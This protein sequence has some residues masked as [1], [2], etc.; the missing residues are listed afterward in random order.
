MKQ[1]TADHYNRLARMTPEQRDEAIVRE[2]FGPLFD[3][4]FPS[5]AKPKAPEPMEDE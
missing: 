2:M 3:S 5:L 4:V 1:S